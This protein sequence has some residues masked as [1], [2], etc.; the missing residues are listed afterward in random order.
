MTTDDQNPTA[1]DYRRAAA[2]ILHRLL[3][4]G[5]RAEYRRS[6]GR[7]DD[8][9]H[10]RQHRAG[11]SPTRPRTTPTMVAWVTP[12]R[13][14]EFGNP[15]VPVAHV[16]RW[17][18]H[19]QPT[20]TLKCVRR[21]GSGNHRK[22]ITAAGGPQ[23][24]LCRFA[25]NRSYVGRAKNGR[26]AQQRSLKILGQAPGLIPDARPGRT[27]GN[28][29][30]PTLSPRHQAECETDAASRASAATFGAVHARNSLSDTCVSP[31]A[32]SI[33]RARQGRATRRS[34]CCA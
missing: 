27:T 1:A 34:R 21:L 23:G 30:S 10:S 26:R 29:P 19:A 7:H 25:G 31:R 17:P 14:I 6:I 9:G 8:S 32:T 22:P 16:S 11:G 4:A 33:A 24:S 18:G 2:L 20:I 5:S 15:G 3:K 28:V 13:S 12:S